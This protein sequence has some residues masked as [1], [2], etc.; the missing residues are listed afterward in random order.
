MSTP[1]DSLSF[2]S[3]T[4][5]SPWGTY[6]AQVDRVIPYLGPLSRWVGTLTR[7]KRTLIVDIPIELDNGR[8]VH[9]EGY[10][11]QH[12]LSRGPGKG[13]VRFHPDVTLEEVMALAAWMTVK[14]AAVNLPFGGAKGGVRV[15]PRTLSHGELERLTRR[16]TSEIGPLIGPQRDIPAPDVN[17]DAQIMAWM[18]DT[19]STN[20]GRDRHRAWSPAN[21]FRWAVHWDG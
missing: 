4:A 16:Y 6:L 1:T 20:V 14:N 11:V 10:R 3:P 2:V 9:Y 17:T 12:S 5:D 7:P 13:G 18:M 21:R 8:I 15:D 19:Y